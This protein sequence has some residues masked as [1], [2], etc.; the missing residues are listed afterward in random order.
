MSVQDEQPWPAV[1]AFLLNP[2]R[3]VDLSDGLWEAWVIGDKAVRSRVELS[4][5]R[6][7]LS[8]V[9]PTA[10]DL[11]RFLRDRLYAAAMKLVLDGVQNK[12]KLNLKCP[13]AQLPLPSQDGSILD[14]K[15]VV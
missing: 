2:M 14:R 5:S 15:S 9:Y 4:K 13:F 6:T 7:I 8:P 10:E 11:E 1:E 3:S 12:A